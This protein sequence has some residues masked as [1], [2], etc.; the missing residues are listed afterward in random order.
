MV[1]KE[2]AFVAKNATMQALQLVHQPVP[3]DERDY[4]RVTQYACKDLFWTFKF[5]TMEEEVLDFTKKG[6]PGEIT[7]AY[8]NAE[9]KKQMQWW[10]E[11]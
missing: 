5:F 8:F 10:N 1:H 9:P 6:S 11:Y 2:A 3:F 7:M 4:T